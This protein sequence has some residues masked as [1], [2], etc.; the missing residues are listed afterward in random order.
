MKSVQVILAV[1]S[2]CPVLLLPVWGGRGEQREKGTNERKNRFF[3]SISAAVARA[4][5][6][7]HVVISSYGST[8]DNKGRG[9]RDA[10][11]SL[12]ALKRIR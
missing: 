9:I 10:G 7:L 4:M 12:C 2:I 5:A 11:A 1:C 6:F 3:E 8:H